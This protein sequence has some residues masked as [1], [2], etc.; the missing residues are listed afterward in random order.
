MAD[1]S[2]DRTDSTQPAGPYGI[3]VL[4]PD[5]AFGSG[6]SLIPVPRSK[7]PSLSSGW[8]PAS[9][10]LPA[11]GNAAADAGRRTGDLLGQDQHG[12]V[13]CFAGMLEILGV[14]EHVHRRVS[15]VVAHDGALCDLA[16]LGQ[17]AVGGGDDVDGARDRRPRANGTGEP[18]QHI[19]DDVVE[20]VRLGERSFENVVRGQ[21]DLRRLG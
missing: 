10:N 6:W 8:K 4:G 9:V 7:V 21:Y 14:D 18:D 5:R 19:G 2:S 20:H 12:G 16:G 1:T 11:V 17:H 3:D 13:E 15:V